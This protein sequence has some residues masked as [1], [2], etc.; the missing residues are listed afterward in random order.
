VANGRFDAFVQQ[1]GLSNWDIA[2][3]GLI[4]EQA[5]A[6]VS[7]ATGGPWFDLDTPDRSIGLVAAPARHHAPILA[8]LRD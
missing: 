8:L 7:D 6:V 3:A 2:A 4:A 5:G 1:T